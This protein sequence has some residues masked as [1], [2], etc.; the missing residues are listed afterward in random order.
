MDK[1]MTSNAD[2]VENI[3]PEETQE[4]VISRRA[5]KRGQSII[6]KKTEYLKVVKIE[7]VD[8][9]KLKPNEYNPN[10]QNEHDFELLLRSME[11]DGF[12]Q[13]IVILTDNTIVDGEHRWRAAKTLGMKT[14]PCVRVKHGKEQAR[15]STLRH[16]RARGSEDI[17]LSTQMLRDLEQLGALEWAKD[18]LMMGDDEINKLLE[19]ISAPEALAGIE[20][21]E[22]WIPEKGIG[23]DVASQVAEGNRDVEYRD[24]K[25]VSTE[26]TGD[27]IRER[28]K[29]I[30][31]AKS[32]EDKETILKD[33]EVT[34]INFIFADADEILLA[35]KY[36]GRGAADILVWLLKQIEKGEIVLPKDLWHKK[37]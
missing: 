11:E 30:K 17:E 14:V 13:P 26:N 12:T 29:M 1:V 9:G 5:L 8:V 32:V 15:I 7:Y 25:L 4:R 6:E 27:R 20:F 28:E 24:I 16:N 35:K 37:V 23:E 2:K 36:L 21:N 31:E 3:T 10:R 33:N 19:D 18:S 34:R 22:G